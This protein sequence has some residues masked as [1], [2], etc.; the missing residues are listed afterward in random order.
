MLGL[1]THEPHFALL[2]EEVRFGKKSKKRQTN[3]DTVTFHL[4]HLSILREYIELEFAALKVC[5]CTFGC[6]LCDSHLSDVVVHGVRL[7][8]VYCDVPL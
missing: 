2:R 5:V 8:S 3:P 6:A 4:L 7:P 1:A